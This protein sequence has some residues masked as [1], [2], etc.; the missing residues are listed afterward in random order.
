MVKKKIYNKARVKGEV[1]DILKKKGPRFSIS[2]D[3][4]KLHPRKQKYNKS[5][6]IYRYQ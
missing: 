3:K 4:S 6:T 5:N 1:H 2:V